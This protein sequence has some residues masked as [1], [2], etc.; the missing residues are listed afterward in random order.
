LVSI[1]IDLAQVKLLVTKM[2]FTSYYYL[3]L[4]L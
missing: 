3:F 1:E 4:T 2:R